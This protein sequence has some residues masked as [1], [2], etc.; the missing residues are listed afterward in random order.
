LHHYDIIGRQ[1]N[2][3]Q[4]YFTINNFIHAGCQ[5]DE[6]EVRIFLSLLATASPNSGV[7]QVWTLVL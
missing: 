7:T 4:W 1:D 3:D 6:R 2:F 5:G